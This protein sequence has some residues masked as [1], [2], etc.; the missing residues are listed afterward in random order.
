MGHLRMALQAVLVVW[1]AG[2]CGAAVSAETSAASTL[3]KEVVGTT[4]GSVEKTRRLVEWLHQNLQWSYTDYQQRTVEQILT[5]RA[6]NCAELARVLQAMLDQAGVKSRWV[7][8]I[9]I[10]PVT[11]RRQATAARKV[12]ELGNR[13]SVFGLRHNDHRWLEVFDEASQSW[14]PADPSIGRVGVDAWTRARLAFSDR[15]RSPIAAVDKVTQEMIAP[16]VVVAV[17]SRSSKV[18]ETRS[19][20]YLVDGFNALYGGKLSA[21]AAWSRWTAAVDQL[22]TAGA[23]AFEGRVN[24]HQH[25]QLIDEAAESYEAL[26]REAAAA[27]IAP[28]AAVSPG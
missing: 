22:A 8:E 13:A 5:R 10:H 7:A 18:T 12:E 23:G 16:V 14:V 27:G 19:T 6:G 4:S 20:H 17:D 25:Q 9:N 11:P 21:L 15:L 3:A 2:W 26:R 24:L 28:T 1:M